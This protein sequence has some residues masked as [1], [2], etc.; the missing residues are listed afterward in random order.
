MLNKLCVFVITH[1][2]FFQHISQLSITLAAQR[3]ICAAV[4]AAPAVK[5]SSI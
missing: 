1:F 5:L 3:L 2:R 4:P